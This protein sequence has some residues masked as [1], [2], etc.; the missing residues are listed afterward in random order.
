MANPM[1]FGTALTAVGLVGML[2]GCSTSGSSVA[3]RASIFGDKVDSSNIGLATRAAAALEKGDTAM[4][5]QLAERAVGNTSND[6]G[7][8]ALLG[9]AYFAAGRFASAQAAYR[10]S[11]TL[12][13]TQSQVALKLVLVTIAQG[14]NGEALDLLGQLRPML[15]P[16]DFGLAMAL[17]GD[18]S[19][20][21]AVLDAS[22]R[23]T[24]ADA[25]VR[26]NLALAHALAGDWTMAREVASQDIAADQL[27]GR[28][29][30]WMTFA[31]PARASDQVASMVG[32]T[33]AAIDPGQPVRLALNAQKDGPRYADV[34]AVPVADNL[35]NKA[36]AAAVDYQA[37]TPVAVANA[38]AEPA[39]V[40][41]PA[42][43]V[44]SSAQAPAPAKEAPVAAIM[45]APVPVVVAAAMPNYVPAIEPVVS[46]PAPAKFVR[47]SSAKPTF[48]HAALPVGPVASG[49]AVVQLGAFSSRSNVA[50]AWARFAA[51]YPSLRDRTPATARLSVNGAM[52]YRLSVSGFDSS[53]EAQGFC[54]SLKRTG[55]N[56]F[57]RTSAG[58]RRVQL[59]SR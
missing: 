1:R 13:P 15:D 20:A 29:Q 4:A 26:Q 11:L 53:R 57:V 33:P 23:Q 39:V 18:A 2:A 44:F 41:T 9:N 22:A 28:I 8:R 34:G 43:V 14:K 35:S 56:C 38:Q 7:F 49:R 59:A 31:K 27:D 51:K 10:D 12:L 50:S 47:A 48:R 52:V 37:A 46:E 24:G 40:E 54:S 16:A 25:R 32:V 58:D 21:V 5:V 45:P 17:A 19:G 6:A 3:S 30:Q 36:P 55:A 42:P